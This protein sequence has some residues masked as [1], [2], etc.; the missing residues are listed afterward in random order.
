MSEKE[1]LNSVS[2]PI[3]IKAEGLIKALQN[4]ANAPEAEKLTRPRK[5]CKSAV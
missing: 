1:N 4:S 3:C 5:S 2:I